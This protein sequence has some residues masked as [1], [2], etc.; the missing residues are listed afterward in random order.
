M[1]NKLFV[2]T[3]IY[4][5]LIFMAITA[6][7][8]YITLFYAEMNMSDTQIG[9][10]TSTGA[11][12]GVLANPFWGGRGDRAKAK[13]NVLLFCLLAST[14][15]V[16]L[17]PLAGGNFLFL[18][19]ITCIFFFF[20][21]AINPLG[22]AISLELASEY[23]FQ[24]SKV[25]TAGSLGFATMSAVAGFMIEYNIHSIFIAY[26]VLIFIAIFVFLKIPPVLGHQVSQKKIHFLE[27]LKSSSLRRIYIY[28]FV[29][30]TGF[31][32]FGSFQALYSVEQG[33]PV[34][35]IGLG[36]MVGSF[37]Q[38]PFMLFFDKLYNYFGIRNIILFSGILLAIRWIL[39]ALWLNSFTVLF[40][41]LLHGG[42]FILIY[43]CLAEY[44]HRHIRK[45]LKVSGQMM[46]FIVLHGLGGI[47]GGILGGIGAD[48]IGYAF[49]FAIMGVMSLIGVIYFWITSRTN[50]ELI[51]PESTL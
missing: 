36:F 12:M 15:I 42:T 50:K 5:T 11:V 51:S 10:L 40:L 21:T 3:C 47:A 31:G 32:F 22:D 46:N 13:N 8:S 28:V 38:F 33:I 26:S 43:L 18:L 24:F 29:L 39:Y 14:I 49:M 6:L 19:I 9:I 30:S 27:V 34:S 44:V 20:Q 17:Y 37:S 7:V 25:R 48:F 45:E 1:K 4:Y 16:W 23:D 35:L 41:W 2:R